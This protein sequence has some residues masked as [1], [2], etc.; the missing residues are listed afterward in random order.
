L[1]TLNKNNPFST[2]T[3]VCCFREFWN[4]S[5]ETG[6]KSFAGWKQNYESHPSAMCYPSE[7]F[8][9]FFIHFLYLHF[10]YT[11]KIYNQNV[12]S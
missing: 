6:F 8:I 12:I 9:F 2:A 11:K 10:C 4:V 1:T 7:R 3:F 5:S